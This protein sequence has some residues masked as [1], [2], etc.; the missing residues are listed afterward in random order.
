MRG[1]LVLYSYG[2]G[3]VL[4]KHY[5]TQKNAHQFADEHRRLG[6]PCEAIVLNLE[7]VVAWVNSGVDE[8]ERIFK[9]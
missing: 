8:L 5:K 6:K 2:R 3:Y 9:L 7:D 4:P 1:W